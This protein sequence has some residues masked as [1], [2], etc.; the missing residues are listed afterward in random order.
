MHTKPLFRKSQMTRGGY[1]LLT[2]LVVSALIILVATGMAR[3]TVRQLQT[4]SII[5]DSFIAQNAAVA[6]LECAYFWDTEPAVIEDQALGPFYPP[7]VKNIS[8]MDGTS[9]TTPTY[10]GQIASAPVD[11]FR[12]TFAMNV[13]PEAC[14]EVEIIKTDTL[15][16][17]LP[18]GG[19][20]PLRMFDTSIISDGYNTQLSGDVCDKTSPFVVQRSVQAGPY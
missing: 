17:Y 16:T 6:G 1:A 10:H 13:G 2:A 9:V 11:T 15:N 5:V 20:V 18:I 7:F 12:Y 3:R 19:V 8:C 14:V 4:H